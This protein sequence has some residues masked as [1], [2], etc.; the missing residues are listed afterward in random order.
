MIDK[1]YSQPKFNLA[2]VISDPRNPLFVQSNSPGNWN[3]DRIALNLQK[4]TMNLAR[5]RDIIFYIEGNIDSYVTF[6]L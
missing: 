3:S 2:R 5:L 4:V 1:L 6:G